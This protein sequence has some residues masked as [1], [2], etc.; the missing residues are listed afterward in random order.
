MHTGTLVVNPTELL[1]PY[2]SPKFLIP[3]LRTISIACSLHWLGFIFYF[4][5]HITRK[6]LSLE[7]GASTHMEQKKKSSNVSQ[8]SHEFSMHQ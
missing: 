1:M 4:L 3:G 6:L 5:S 2:M 7:Q 8:S